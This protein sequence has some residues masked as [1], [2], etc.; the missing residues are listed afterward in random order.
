MQFFSLSLQ[1]STAQI[2]TEDVTVHNLRKLPTCQWRSKQK[3]IKGGRRRGVKEGGGR[4]SPFSPVMKLGPQENNNVHDIDSSS[5]FSRGRA[6][7]RER[8]S[9][10]EPLPDLSTFAVRFLIFLFYAR[11]AFSLGKI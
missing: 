8:A 6:V 10:R 7:V 2:D 9:S 4:A 5:A 3:L 11:G 1:L